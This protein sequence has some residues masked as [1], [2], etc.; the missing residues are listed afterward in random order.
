M[1]PNGNMKDEKKAD[2]NEDVGNTSDEELNVGYG[3][4]FIC[5]NRASD[6]N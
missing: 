3:G 2:S 5:I 1:Q 4:S 6:K